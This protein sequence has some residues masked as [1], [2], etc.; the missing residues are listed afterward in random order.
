MNFQ[1]KC[2]VKSLYLNAVLK[3][4]CFPGAAQYALLYQLSHIYFKYSNILYICTN[5]NSLIK[6]LNAA[7]VL[8]LFN[9]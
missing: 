5:W 9:F 4:K 1:K 2:L 8:I 3:D 6:Y 7:F